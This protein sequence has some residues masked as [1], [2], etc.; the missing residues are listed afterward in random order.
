MFDIHY[1]IKYRAISSPGN[2]RKNNEDNLFCGGKIISR[3]EITSFF[4]VSG[5]LDSRNNSLIA[6]FDGMGGEAKGDT[7]SY[8]AAKSAIDIEFDSENLNT[9][10]L[11]FIKDINRKVKDY[12]GRHNVEVMGT[13]FA[14]I[15]FSEKDVYIGNV[16]DSRVYRLHS[17]KIEQL[18]VDHSLPKELAFGNIITQYIG[19]GENKDKFDP[20]IVFNGYCSHDRYIICSD[21]LYEN[22]KDD[23]IGALCMVAETVDDAADILMSQALDL[24][25][26]DNITVIVCEVELSS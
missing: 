11:N 16:G 24:G 15:I 18:S 25:G 3:S 26:N 7:A 21:G 20:V 12:A 19:M 2:V 5:V 9:Q 4:S 23:E 6:V 22:L 17:G 8:L 13:T 1:K 14:G 10:M